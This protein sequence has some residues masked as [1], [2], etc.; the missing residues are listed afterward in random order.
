MTADIESS[1]FTGAAF[2]DRR[3]AA[4][5][6]LQELEMKMW[7]SEPAPKRTGAGAMLAGLARVALAVAAVAA[8]VALVAGRG[9]HAA[10]RELVAVA[11]V[12]DVVETPMEVAVAQ[13]WGLVRGAGC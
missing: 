3:A 10:R 11:D 12:A 5:A 8:G 9:Q 13:V 6:N 4:L 7:D 1:P 2:K